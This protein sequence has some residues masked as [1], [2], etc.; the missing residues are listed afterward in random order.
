MTGLFDRS[1]D[2]LCPIVV[3]SATSFNTPWRGSSLPHPKRP[4]D[5]KGFIVEVYWEDFASLY[6]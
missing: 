1:G 5:L 4:S 2:P 3:G 6:S